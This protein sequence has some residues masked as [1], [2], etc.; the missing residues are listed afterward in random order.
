MEINLGELVED[1]IGNQ[2]RVSVKLENWRRPG[3]YQYVL[4]EES[5]SSKRQ[6]LYADG[7][8]HCAASAVVRSLVRVINENTGTAN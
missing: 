2:W 1:N 3:Y 6:A 4:N 7:V 5:G 8:V